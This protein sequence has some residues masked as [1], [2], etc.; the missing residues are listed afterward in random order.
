[1]RQNKFENAKPVSSLLFTN[2]ANSKTYGNSLWDLKC[3]FHFS[4]EFLFVDMFRS[5][6][7]LASYARDAR[8]IVVRFQLK[9][10]YADKF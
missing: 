8:G 5:E 4:L 2:L 6:K 10:E 9:L 7:H 3:M 1:M